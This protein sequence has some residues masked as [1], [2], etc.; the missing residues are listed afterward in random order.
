MSGARGGD[1]DFLG[2]LA[3]RHLQIHTQTRA[4]L[5]LHVV[6]E[7]DREAGLLGGHDVEARLDGGEL[8]V[9]VAARCLDDRDAG[10]DAGQRHLRA[11][12][13]TA[14]DVS[15]TVPTTVAVSNCARALVADRT[16]MHRHARTNRMQH[17]IEANQK[18]PS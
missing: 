4:D 5:D 9:A 17:L 2:E 15:R 3:D 18:K 14:P 1:L 7:R 10:F 16:K 12:G 6:D 8:V 13:T 11:E